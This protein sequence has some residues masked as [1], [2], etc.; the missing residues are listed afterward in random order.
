MRCLCEYKEGDTVLHVDER[1]DYK[2]LA[3]DEIDSLGG[4]AS[5]GLK[6]EFNTFKKYKSYL[7]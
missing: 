7:P 3:W 2:W 6:R 4:N 5:S 1:A